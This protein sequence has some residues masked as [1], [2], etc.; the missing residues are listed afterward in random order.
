MV[1][2]T[3]IVKQVIEKVQEY[4]M[5]IK[6]LFVNFRQG[7]DTLKRRQFVEALEHLGIDAKLRRLMKMMKIQ[8]EVI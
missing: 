6:M 4:N 5:E 2:A 7:F 8:S 1:N 3:H